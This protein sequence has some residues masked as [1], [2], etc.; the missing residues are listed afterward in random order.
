ME[1]LPLICNQHFMLY[2][3]TVVP[4]SIYTR[5]YGE[6]LWYVYPI[7]HVKYLK[8]ICLLIFGKAFYHLQIHSV[9]YFMHS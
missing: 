4:Q 8:N 5:F 1:L 6:L 3:L 9:I 7:A 2:D